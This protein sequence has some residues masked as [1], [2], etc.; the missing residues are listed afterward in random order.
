MATKDSSKE[1]DLPDELARICERFAIAW[2]S[3]ERPSIEEFVDGRDEPARSRIISALLVVEWDLRKEVGPK[4]T[5]SEFCNRYPTW[6]NEFQEELTR[7]HREDESLRFDS[8]RVVMNKGNDDATIAPQGGDSDQ[9]GLNESDQEDLTVLPSVTMIGRYRVVQLLGQGGFGQV[10]L[11]FDDQLKRKV[12]IKVPTFGASANENAAAEYLNEART[13]AELD[14]PHIVAVFDVGSTDEHPCFIVSKF[15]EGMDLSRRM[16]TTRLGF[17]EIA[18]LI[19]T[20]A[21]ALHLAHGKQIVHRDIKPGNILLD[22]DGNPYVADF[23][24]ALTKAEFGKQGGVMGTPSYMSPEQAKGD[25]HLVDGRSDIYSLGVVLYELL[26]GERPFEGSKWMDVVHRIATVEARPPRQIDDRIPK[27]LERICLMAMSK[28]PTQRYTTAADFA[29]DLDAFLDGFEKRQQ[30]SQRSSAQPVEITSDSLKNSDTVISCA[31]LDD[32]PL[33]PDEE[34]WIA[35]L[36]R[37]LQVRLSQLLGE[38]VNVMSFPAPSGRCDIDEELLQSVESA[39]TIVSVLSPPFANSEA[40]QRVARRAMQDPALRARFFQ[41]V[42][43]PWPKNQFS[44]DFERELSQLAAYRFFEEDPQSNR[45][46]EFDERFGVEARQRY[47]ERVYDLAQEISQTLATIRDTP[48]D[49]DAAGDEDQKVVYLASSSFDLQDDYDNIRRELTAR[50]HEV[51]PDQPLPLELKQLES[52]IRQHLDQ[53]DFAI[54]L[55]G[56]SYGIIPEGSNDSMISIQNRIAAEYS[57][58]SNLARLIWLADPAAENDV[59]QREF[60]STLRTDPDIHHGAEIVQDNLVGVK[61]LIVNQLAPKPKPQIE[62]TQ[63]DSDTSGRIYLICDRKDEAATEDLEDFLFDQGFE[64]S[65]PDFDADEEEAAEV[66]RQN[67]VDCDGVIVYYG[68]VRHS[69]VDIKLRNVLKANGYGRTKE[70]NAIAVHI[71]AP[72]DRRKQRFKSHLAEVIRQESEEFDGQLLQQF[73]GKL[74]NTD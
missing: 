52:R 27:E 22:T 73:L 66:H 5:I 37:N 54:H 9:T 67:L 69:W 48:T 21:D 63:N 28:S 4:L 60:L 62:P 36:Q 13:L 26:T 1:I 41:V 42:K 8:T 74:R 35:K 20:I 31:Q 51:L 64:V 45:I 44:P 55:I 11:A 18:E 29:A 16:S 47:F 59:R 40:C 46:K 65:L 49:A 70:L 72:V 30:K 3:G 50:G 58:S 43:T 57:K 7:L 25:A 23:G 61:T 56:G 38:S 71:G 14:H 10:F 32:E 34:G 19:S 6:A 15:I 68:A 24:L 12:A 17:V 2:R 33:S 39:K 53:C